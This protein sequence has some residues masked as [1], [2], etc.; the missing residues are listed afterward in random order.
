MSVFQKYLEMTFA[1]TALPADEAIQISKRISALQSEDHKE[2]INEIVNSILDHW[3]NKQ[4]N[5]IY[6]KLRIMDKEELIEQI[7]DNEF[8]PN[9]YKMYSNKMVV[10]I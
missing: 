7:I 4:R 10:Q 1:R 3:I 9:T 6:N 2:L 5:K 8:G